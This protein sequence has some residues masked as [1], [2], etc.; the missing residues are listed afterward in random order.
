MFIFSY[1]YYFYFVD[2]LSELNKQAKTKAKKSDSKGKKSPTKSSL[3]KKQVKNKPDK[4]KDASKA[5]DELQLKQ[6]EVEIKSIED[7]LSAMIFPSSTISPPAMETVKIPDANPIKGLESDNYE[8]DFDDSGFKEFKM[9]ENFDIPHDYI[10]E[11]VP[12]MNTS[13]DSDTADA[14][15]ERPMSPLTVDIPAVSDLVSVSDPNIGVKNP[16]SVITPDSRDSSPTSAVPAVSGV[17]AASYGLG[18]QSL[19]TPGGGSMLSPEHITY[20]S[21]DNSSR[22]E[23]KLYLLL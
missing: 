23:V 18:S 20:Y 6:R 7:K 10:Q 14:L 13:R 2:Y 21:K 1:C 5:H 15:S 17:V 8:N 22:K 11:I 16:S 19:K 12:K 9:P 4:S 3:D